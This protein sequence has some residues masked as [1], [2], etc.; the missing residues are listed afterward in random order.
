MLTLDYKSICSSESISNSIYDHNSEHSFW[1]VGVLVTGIITGKFGLWISD[2]TITQLLQ[3]N[4]LE[5]HSKLFYQTM[6]DKYRIFL[7][8]VLGQ[9]LF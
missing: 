2:L 7:N 9:K 1:S 3:E 6:K 5:E 4:V 8:N